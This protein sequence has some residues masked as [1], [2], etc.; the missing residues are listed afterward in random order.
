MLASARFGA[1][2]DVGQWESNGS[3]GSARTATAL[4][5]KKEA[6]CISLLYRAQANVDRMIG[7]SYFYLHKRSKTKYLLLVP[8]T[9]D[10][11][12]RKERA[13][14]RFSP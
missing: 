5:A 12:T 10:T 9:S 4:L 6:T 8:A 3:V 11:R 13:I 14:L 7:P 1:G 2:L